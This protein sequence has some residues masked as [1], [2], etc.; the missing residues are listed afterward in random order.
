MR[1]LLQRVQFGSVEVEGEQ[2]GR[3]DEGLVALVG[4]GEGDAESLLLPMAQKLVHLRVFSDTQGKFNY[5]LLDTADL[6]TP[7]GIL[8]VPQFTLY[9]DARRGRRPDFA[10]ALKPQLA[11]VLFE[12]FTHIV[13]QLGV[14]RVATGRFGADMNVTLCNQGPVTILLDSK[15]VVSN[16]LGD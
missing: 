2:I 15:D 13:G 11:A 12:K 14:A 7:R 10:K 16:A 4:F 5:N 9:A 8:L 3:I 6:D 1:I